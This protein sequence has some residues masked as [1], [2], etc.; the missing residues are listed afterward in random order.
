MKRN[1]DLPVNL[2]FNNMGQINVAN[3]QQSLKGM[4]NYLHTTYSAEVSK[5]I[6]KM[7]AIMINVEEEPVLQKDPITKNDI[8][9]VIVQ[10]TKSRPYNVHAHGE[11]CELER[12]T[13]SM[14]PLWLILSGTSLS[15]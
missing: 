3:V 12:H 15:S 6:L 7:Q 5:A 8:Q 2:V 13:I 14:P 4:P 11:E 10:S 9:S 1:N